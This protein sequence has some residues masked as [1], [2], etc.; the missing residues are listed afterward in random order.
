MF[1]IVDRGSNQRYVVPAKS[2]DES[3]VRLL[4]A[5]HEEESLTV[6]TDGFLA[7]EPLED[8][9]EYQREAVL[10]SEGEYVTNCRRTFG[11]FSSDVESSANQDEPRSN[12]SFEPCSN[13]PTTC[14]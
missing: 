4:L 3:T 14:F 1:T 9:T 6:Y 7:Y 5:D 13:S 2:D 10:H 12:R 8:D 11:R